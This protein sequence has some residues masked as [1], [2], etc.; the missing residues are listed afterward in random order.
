L[1]EAD[2][3]TTPEPTRPRKATVAAVLLLLFGGIGIL[4]TLA[5]L[6]VDDH[7]QSVPTAVSVLLYVQFLFSATLVLCG[8]LIWQ[9]CRPW[10][11]LLAIVLCSFNIVGCLVAL[12]TGAILQ[13][14]WGIGINVGL[15]GL[16]SND[17]VR[18]WCDR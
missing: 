7:G 18:E 15:I 16:L 3:Q 1:Y 12:F 5:L 14:L 11:R 9:G 4:T 2:V 8:V 6:S 10:A 13:A 17:E